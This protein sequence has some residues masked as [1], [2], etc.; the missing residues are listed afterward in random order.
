MQISGEFPDRLTTALESVRISGNI[1]VESEQCKQ[2]QYNN[3]GSLYLSV[4]P[5]FYTK[6]PVKHLIN[7][8]TKVTLSFWCYPR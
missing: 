5:K 4:T 8:K 6:Q 2:E 1:H 3:I 7:A